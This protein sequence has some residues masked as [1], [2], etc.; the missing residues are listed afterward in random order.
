[1]N[2]PKALGNQEGKP[3]EEFTVETNEFKIT[4]RAFLFI[5]S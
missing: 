3:H 4:S 1:M 2:Y 5:Y